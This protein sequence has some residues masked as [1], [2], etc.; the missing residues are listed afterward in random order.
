MMQL[1]LIRHARG[2]PLSELGVRQAE[3]LRDRL[4][5]TD[6]IRAD[7]LLSSTLRRASQTAELVAP[8]LGLPPGTPLVLDDQ[9]VERDAGDPAELARRWPSGGGP[10]WVVDPRAAPVPGAES[11]SAFTR[12]VS[13]ALARITA[14]HAGKT[15]VV[16]CHGGV[17]GAATLSFAGLDT[18]AACYALMYPLPEHRPL[19]GRPWLLG[20]RAVEYT[21][22]THWRR[23]AGGGLPVWE[24][25][26]F[27]DALHLRDLDTAERLNWA[28]LRP[29]PP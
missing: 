21:S 17:I 7:V 24:L 25:K 23:A 27:N 10:D 5:A 12:R 3:R 4:A 22:I 26:R 28:A 14:G 18:A 13:R 1:Y 20:F 2:G 15:V 19:L 9:L 6:E 16:V 8:A 11:P 29:T